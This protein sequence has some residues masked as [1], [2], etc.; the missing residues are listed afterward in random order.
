MEL[1]SCRICP[2]ECGVN[3]TQDE[4]G[5][6]LTGARVF[7]ARAALH[8][9]EEPCISGTAGSGAVFFCGCNLHCIYCQ[10]GSISSMREAMEVSIDRLAEIFLELAEKGAA[11]INLVTPTHYSLQ[12]REAVLLARAGGLSLPIVYNCSGYE[13]VE[14]LRMLEDVIDIYL[15]D[16]KYED[17]SL[18]GVFS[19]APDYPEVAKAALQEMVRQKPECVFDGNGMMK[20]GV[21]VRHLLLPGHVKN[22]KAAVEH[23]YRTYGDGVY[24]SLMSQYTPVIHS[25]KY[26]EL[27]RKTTK[28]EYE[29][30][31]DH[32]LELGVTNAFIQEGGVAEESFIPAF[33]FEGVSKKTEK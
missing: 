26:P 15:T 22:S 13:K 14:T 31:L 12:I 29:K 23:V 33:D 32:V 28:R 1:E 24:I 6:C 17:G 16:Y 8:F 30:L 21:I 19:C 2:R 27:N 5:A 9:W 25:E 20:E 4:K 11:N 7:L 18:A 10:N 3:R